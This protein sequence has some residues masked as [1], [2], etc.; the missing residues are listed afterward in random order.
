[1]AINSFNSEIKKTARNFLMQLENYFKEAKADVLFYNGDIDR[2]YEQMFRTAIEGLVKEHKKNHRE[3]L[4][5]I[6]QT[7][8]GSV[9]TAEKYVKY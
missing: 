9:E 3:T 8:G 5:V 1:M 6:L 2:I 4:I 7:N